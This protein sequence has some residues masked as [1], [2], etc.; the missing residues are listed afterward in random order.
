MGADQS[1]SHLS[2]VPRVNDSFRGTGTG[3]QQHV[4]SLTHAK[5]IRRAGRGQEVWIIQDTEKHAT[6]AAKR[7]SIRG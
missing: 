5:G 1:P 6:S 7:C 2:F 3:S 4:M